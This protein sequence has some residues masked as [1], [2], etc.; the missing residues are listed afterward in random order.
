MGGFEISGVPGTI[1]EAKRK[2]GASRRMDDDHAP[3]HERTVSCL[4]DVSDERFR[5]PLLALFPGCDFLARS[6]AQEEGGSAA[7]LRMAKKLP[8]VSVVCAD[9]SGAEVFRAQ[10]ARPRGKPELRIAAGA[11]RMEVP[12]A[13]V[14]SLPR[15]AVQRVDDAVGVDLV[16]NVAVAQPD[17]PAPAADG[18]IKAPRKRKKGET[19]TV[20][21]EA[22]ANG[23]A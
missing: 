18:D 11:E 8:E 4:L 3:T 10:V 23:A 19:V 14:V 1:T 12:I 17:L 7:V 5:L 20:E 13:L 9:A 15:E 22:P 16:F 2:S 21:V 6:M